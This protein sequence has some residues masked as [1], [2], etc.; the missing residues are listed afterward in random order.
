MH[1]PAVKNNIPS[2][3]HSSIPFFNKG[4]EES[5]FTINKT[6]NTIQRQPVG[7]PP[8]PPPPLP[9]PKKDKKK[10]ANGEMSWELKAVSQISAD[11]KVEFNP[12]KD[13]VDAKSIAIV[14]T[15]KP[16]LG[17]GNFY[18]GGGSAAFS[19][20][21]EPGGRFVDHI[22]ASENDPFYGAMW[23]QTTKSWVSEGANLGKPGSSEKGTASDSTKIHD[24]PN[25]PPARSGKGDLDV[26]FEDVPTI[27]ETREELGALTWGFKIEDKPNSP[28]VLT[29]AEKAD[30]VE[31]PSAAH[32]QAVDK[33]YEAKF[34]TILDDFAINSATL[35]ADHKTKLDVVAAKLKADATLKVE[36]GG[37][38]DL[39]GTAAFNQALSLK[40]AN[41]AKAY[42]VAKGVTN[43]IDIQS[44]GFDWARVKTTKGTSEEKNRRVQ[45]WVHK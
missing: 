42:L 35:T 22:P 24:T 32:E 13:K 8:P 37:A 11:I 5:F 23:D 29:G 45:V 7:G 16:R 18:P 31:A 10:L 17:A 1:Q 40:R 30:C 4:G 33:F 36:L 19:K 15:V 2:N 20:F 26:S 43:T 12:D 44:Y 38:A 3:S 27:Q 41:A 28:I 14:Q 6:N 39:T 9:A 34:D 21:E 25:I